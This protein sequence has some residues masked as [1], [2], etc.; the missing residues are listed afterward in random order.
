MVDKAV[1]G[2]KECGFQSKTDRKQTNGRSVMSDQARSKGSE[3]EK[4]RLLTRVMDYAGWERAFQADFERMCQ[5][6]G[7]PICWTHSSNGK[8]ARAS[9]VAGRAGD[10]VVAEFEGTAKV[11]S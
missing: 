7:T 9:L 11:S 3:G 1:L 5:T 2:C 10:S 6:T 8:E 4:G